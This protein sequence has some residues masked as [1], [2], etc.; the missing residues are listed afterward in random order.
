V[1]EAARA[2]A[3]AEVRERIALR[4]FG[5]PED[6]AALVVFL[7]SDAASFMTGSVHAVDGGYVER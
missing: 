4:R 2:L 7:L 6:V 5:R 3:G 1:L